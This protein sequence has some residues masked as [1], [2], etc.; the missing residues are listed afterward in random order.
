MLALNAYDMKCSLFLQKYTRMHDRS[1]HASE[2]RRLRSMNSWP[3]GQNYEIRVQRFA[4]LI[5]P[6][7]LKALSSKY[8]SYFSLSGIFVTLRHERS[9][10]RVA[11][12]CGLRAFLGLRLIHCNHRTNAPHSLDVFRTSLVGPAELNVVPAIGVSKITVDPVSKIC[13][14]ARRVHN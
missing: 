9:S 14:W 6:Q 1:E 13:S 4:R 11:S 2:C 3:V 12:A 8:A 5:L 10:F 7:I